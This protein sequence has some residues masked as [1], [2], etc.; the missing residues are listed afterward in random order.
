[1]KNNLPQITLKYKQ[2]SV[3]KIK[4]T[5]S[6]DAYNLLIKLYDIDTIDYLETFI[7]LFLDRANQTIGWIKLSQGGISGT[8]VDKKVLMATALKSGASSII[9][10]H[11][12][13]SGNLKP[14]KSD[15]DITNQVVEAGKI[16]D[17]PV[18][19]HHI[20]TSNGYYSFADE[21]ML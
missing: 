1:M 4:I 18:L 15:I 7:V 3:K 5:S 12:H 17:I 19:D 20:I 9:L 10:S 14:S 8:V 11:N 2:G 6:K 16:L 21:F 13:P